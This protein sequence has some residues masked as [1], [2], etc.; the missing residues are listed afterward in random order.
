MMSTDPARAAIQA[1]G[2]CPGFD[3][4]LKATTRRCYLSGP[5]IDA[6]V[7]VDF[8]SADRLLLRRRWRSL[9]K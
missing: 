5:P 3:A 6:P 1:M 7:T 8:G 2:T 9:D 4:T